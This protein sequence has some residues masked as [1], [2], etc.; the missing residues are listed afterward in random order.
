MTNLKI[1]S[2]INAIIAL[3]FIS[4]LYSCKGQDKINISNLNEPSSSIGRVVLELDKD[5]VSIYQDTK[6]NMWFGSM[7]KGVYKYDGES[8]TLFSKTD[9]LAGHVVLSIQEDK[10]GNLYFDT[11]EGISVFDGHKFFALTV[12]DRGP[13]KNK[14]KLEEE[15]LWFRSG[16]DKSGPFR[17]DGTHLYFLELPENVMEDSFNILYPKVH[18]NPYGVYSIYKDTEG[19]MWFGTS[20]L[21]LY[22]YDGTSMSWMY[23][24]HLTQTGNGGSFGIRSIVED[25]NGY[26]WICNPTYKYM[27]ESDSLD[28]GELSLLNYKRELGANSYDGDS[29]YFL[30]M[31]TD[32]AG[33]IWMAGYDQGLWRMNGNELKQYPLSGDQEGLV[34]LFVYIDKK[35]VI[36][37]GTQNS[38]VYK[39]NGNSFDKFEL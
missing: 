5:I 19:S 15:D 18:Y 25:S 14:W 39:Y 10:L 6:L 4:G 34:F 30:S 24:E 17:Y 8:L 29:L 20:S 21:G 32:S 12:S 28:S 22:R 23:E 16:W 1:V 37:L 13:D 35:G 38:G 33:D 11:T 2:L 26:M 3:L 9:G 7:N 31:T 36:W 27:M